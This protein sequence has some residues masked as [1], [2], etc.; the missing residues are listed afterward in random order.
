MAIQINWI[1]YHTTKHILFPSL[2]SRFL[3]HGLL[4]GK[5]VRARTLPCNEVRSYLK[6][7]VLQSSFTHWHMFL[8]A[9]IPQ[10]RSQQ[11]VSS[12]GRSIR[13]YPAD[14]GDIAATSQGQ[15]WFFPGYV[16]Q[17]KYRENENTSASK[18]KLLTHLPQNEN[19]IHPS[20]TCLFRKMSAHPSLGRLGRRQLLKQHKQIWN[21]ELLHLK[22]FTSTEYLWYG[23]WKAWN[24]FSAPP[25][26]DISVKDNRLRMIF[27]LEKK[28]R[29]K[30]KK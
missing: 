27:T 6:Q 24:L 5:K 16:T 9:V 10:K 4:F 15:H 11:L 1:H 20:Q 12:H 3:N 21:L 30:E 8:L 14:R 23:H 25:S 2:K 17:V 22:S 13:N 19:Y 7:S 29:P 26:T 28:N 18:C